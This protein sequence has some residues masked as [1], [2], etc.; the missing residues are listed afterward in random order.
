VPGYEALEHETGRHRCWRD[1]LANTGLDPK[2]SWRA[3]VDSIRT[4]TFCS[5]VS[6]V[7]ADARHCRIN[8]AMNSPWVTHY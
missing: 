2:K 8:E 3:I 7:P 6:A 5:F 4:K 1:C